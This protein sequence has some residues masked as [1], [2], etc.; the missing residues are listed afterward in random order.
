ME[1]EQQPEKKTMTDYLVLQRRILNGKEGSW[2]IWGTV[3]ESDV[4]DIIEEGARKKIP[5]IA[6]RTAPAQQA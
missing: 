2:R 5:H 4:K 6:L 1:G 3:Q